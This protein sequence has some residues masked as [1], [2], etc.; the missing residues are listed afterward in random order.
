MS[1]TASIV[2]T[3]SNARHVASKAVFAL[4]DV[5]IDVGGVGFSIQG[6]Q[7]RN[8]ATGGTSIHLPTFKDASGISRPAILL[9]EEL[10]EPLTRAVLVFLVEEGLAVPAAPLAAQDRPAPNT[11]KHPCV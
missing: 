3:V 1:E 9:P 6:V 4:V 5:A 10:R 11:V 7:A 2:C 8:L